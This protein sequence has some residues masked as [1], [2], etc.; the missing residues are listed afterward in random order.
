M[1]REEII[2]RYSQGQSIKSIAVEAE[3]SYTV[4]RRVLITAMIPLRECLRSHHI[5]DMLSK[6]KSIEDVADALHI[7]PRTVKEYLPYTK[8]SYAVDPKSENAKKIDMCRS[9]KRTG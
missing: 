3:V 4:V 8:C 7:T 2:Q 5:I 6:G 9:R 1:I